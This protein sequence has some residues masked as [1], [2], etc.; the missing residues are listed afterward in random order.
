VRTPAALTLARC[1]RAR[2]LCRLPLD[3]FDSRADA[4]AFQAAAVQ[5]LGG[6]RC[7][8]KIGATSLEVQ[9]L[10]NCDERR[11]QTKLTGR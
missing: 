2:T 9:R 10:L 11:C 3:K 4:E 1:R 8:Y 5:A 6:S 7:G